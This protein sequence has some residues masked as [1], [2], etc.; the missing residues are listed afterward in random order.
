MEG[1]LEPKG[2][3]KIRHYGLLASRQREARLRAARRLLLPKLAL[4]TG[5]TTQIEPA[6]PARCPHCGSVRRVRGAL[7]PRVASCPFVCQS[8]STPAGTPASDTS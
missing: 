6:E 8:R 3:M 5:A 7:L 4:S 2:F 1:S